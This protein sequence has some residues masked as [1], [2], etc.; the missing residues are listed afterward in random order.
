MLVIADAEKPIAIAGV[1]GGAQSEVKE[2][3]RRVLLESAYFDPKSVRRTARAL[4]MQTEASARFQRGADPEMARYAIDRAASMMQEILGAT[5]AAGILDEYPKPV[6]RREVELRFERTH[7]L[8]GTRIAPEA[9]KRIL[10]NLGFELR[11]T[12]HSTCTVR[13]PSWRHDVQREEDLIEEIARLHG[14]DRIEATLPKI[15]QADM[16]LAPHETKLH[17]LRHF[18]VGLGLTEFVNMSFSSPEETRRAGLDDS[19][20]NMVTLAN[21]LSANQGTLRTSLL[22]GMIAT[23][24]RNTRYGYANI[25]AFELGPVFHPVASQELPLEPTHLAM[26]LT[27]N[28]SEKHWS[29]PAKTFNFFD[30]KGYA[31]AICDYLAVPCRF[32]T[33]HLALYQP[34]Q[35]GSIIA[36][37]TALGTFG[38]LREA[39]LKAHDIEQPLY[40]LEL[41]LDTPLRRPCPVPRFIPIDHF[42]AAHRDLAILVDASVPAGAISNAARQAAGTLLR[43]VHLFDLYAGEQVPQGKKSLALSLSFQADER[44]LTDAEVQDAFDS[45]LQNLQNKFG[46]VQR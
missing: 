13:V 34:G 37:E 32:E 21:P 1:M 15:P 30:I 29:E 4:G 12:T 26:V 24:S 28:A 40:Y 20:L 44:T 27:G 14:Y 35:C 39:I 8:I 33:T 31:E 41:D 43:K 25:G 3:T 6:N 46:A 7:L 17:R 42:P 5:V 23:V 16:V 18:L 22:P 11:S 38:Q 19:Y 9:Q 45:V 10:Q 2:T 36:E